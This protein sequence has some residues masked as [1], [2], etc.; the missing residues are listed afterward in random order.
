MSRLLELS[1]PVVG[2][3]VSID[4]EP[5]LL[6]QRRGRVEGGRLV[7]ALHREGDRLEQPAPVVGDHLG[8]DLSGGAYT[9]VHDP[10]FPHGSGLREAPVP[11]NLDLVELAEDLVEGKLEGGIHGENRWL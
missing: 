8:I 3:D 1:A 9:E 11:P 2:H 5:L 7:D 10:L 4:G 6:R